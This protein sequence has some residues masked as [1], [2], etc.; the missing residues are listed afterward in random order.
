VADRQALGLRK[1]AALAYG[2]P[3]ESR[4]KRRMHGTRW[5]VKT[6]LLA[7][8]ADR[9]GLLA[10]SM[11]KDAQKKRN[12]PKS[13]LEILLGEPVKKTDVVSFDSPEAFERA[14]AAIINA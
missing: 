11:T 2:L 6:Q 8:L 1:A 7:I 9:I 3:E 13:L 14:R 12:K 4:V 5:D 10:W